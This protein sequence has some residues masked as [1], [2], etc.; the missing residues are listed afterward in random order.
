MFAI[1]SPGSAQT[2]ETQMLRVPANEFQTLQHD[3]LKAM[4][5]AITKA[6]IVEQAQ[7]LAFMLVSFAL[8]IGVLEVIKRLGRSRAQLRS[9]LPEAREPEPDLNWI[10]GTKINFDPSFTVPTVGQKFN[11]LTN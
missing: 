1:G 3:A 11:D 5:T 7:G 4:P 6:E 10:I 9:R 2:L 8:V